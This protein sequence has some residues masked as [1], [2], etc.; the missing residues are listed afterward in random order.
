MTTIG[1]ELAI[2]AAAVGVGALVDS[3]LGTPEGSVAM[4]QVVDVAH[5]HGADLLVAIPAVTAGV[6]TWASLQ[7]LRLAGAVVDRLSGQHKVHSVDERA[8]NEKA[9]RDGKQ[10]KELAKKTDADQNHGWID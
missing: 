5:R 1:K 4:K 10:S 7:G 2:G 6:T 3:Y 8:I 9:A